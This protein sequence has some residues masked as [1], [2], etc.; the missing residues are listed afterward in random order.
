M[1][2]FNKQ[3]KYVLIYSKSKFIFRAKP[4]I[5]KK[6]KN[7]ASDRKTKSL[8]RVVKNKMDTRQWRNI[9]V[10]NNII[11]PFCGDP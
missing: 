1:S 2:M 6:K 5:K 11:P 10:N 9:K 4:Q 8:W 7:T 3:Y